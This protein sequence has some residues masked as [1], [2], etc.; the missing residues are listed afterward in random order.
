MNI[1]VIVCIQ[2]HLTTFCRPFVHYA[3]LRL[4]S[5]IVHFIRNNCLYFVCY[6]WSAHAL[7][8]LA[9]SPIYGYITEFS[10]IRSCKPGCASGRPVAHFLCSTARIRQDIREASCFSCKLLWRIDECVLLPCFKAQL[11]MFVVM[12][13]CVVPFSLFS[14]DILTWTANSY[15]QCNDT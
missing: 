6:G 4:C 9:T 11:D 5:A 14:S 3:C 1:W 2:N 8:A 13:C 12:N 10:N 15:I 7:T